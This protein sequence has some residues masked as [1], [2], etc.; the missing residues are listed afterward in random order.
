M[1]M[2]LDLPN[3]LNRPYKVTYSS[4]RCQYVTERFANIMLGKEYEAMA[5]IATGDAYIDIEGDKWERARL[6]TK[7]FRCKFPGAGFD[8]ITLEQVAQSSYLEVE[9]GLIALEA[10]DVGDETTDDYGLTWVR[11]E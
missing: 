3:V 11:T 9:E 7:T 8:G 5:A 10:L 1:T 6:S 2:N 4:G